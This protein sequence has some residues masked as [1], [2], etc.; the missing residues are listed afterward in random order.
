[1]ARVEAVH[2]VLKA[3]GCGEIPRILVRNKCDLSERPA[4]RRGG[5]AVR[6]SATTGD[7]L[8]ILREMVKNRLI[9]QAVEDLQ[10]PD[11]GDDSWSPMD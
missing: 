3:I 11:P 10:G 1:M 5:Q 6:V 9:G 7:G 2:E 8:T 4:G